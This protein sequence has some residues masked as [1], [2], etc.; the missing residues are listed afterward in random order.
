[1]EALPPTNPENMPDMAMLAGTTVVFSFDIEKAGHRFF[2]DVLQVGYAVVSQDLQLLESGK[3]SAYYGEM[4]FEPRCKAEFWDK[5]P[6]KLA[7]IKK[8]SPN[9]FAGQKI[10]AERFVTVLANWG[11]LSKT[12]DF[13]LEIAS[14]NLGY[15]PSNINMLIERTLSPSCPTLPYGMHD[16]EYRPMLETDSMLYAL[17]RMKNKGWNSH[18]GLDDEFRRL[19][20]VPPPPPWA[21][22]DHDAERDACNI[23]YTCQQLFSVFSS[24]QFEKRMTYGTVT[25]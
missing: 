11:H 5:H 2:Y 17:I 24:V 4:P 18:W 1:M 9:S 23:A 19:Y 15:D 21:I 13:C 8:D 3:A 7:A 16:L 14:D 12:H 10:M 22:A 20:T 25:T 6:E